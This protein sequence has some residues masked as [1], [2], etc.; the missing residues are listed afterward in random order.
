MIGRRLARLFDTY[1]RT[2]I[3]CGRG[4]AK[5]YI[6]CYRCHKARKR[7]NWHDPENLPELV[8]HDDTR[9]R[10]EFYVYVLDTS[11]GQY[12]G[13][14]GNL[15]ARMRAHTS[16]QVISTAGGEP[17]LIWKSRPIATRAGATRFEAALKSWRDNA[18]PEFRETTGHDASPFRK[19][20]ESHA[21]FEKRLLRRLFRSVW[22]RVWNR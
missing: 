13:H 18:R 6:R 15:R 9:G 7:G 11:Y 14:T 2:C 12:V 5:P 21:R 3:N 17:K 19:P 10:S 1:D 4:I 16:G 8:T 22:A 20:H